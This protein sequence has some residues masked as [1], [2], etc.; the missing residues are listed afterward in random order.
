M[1]SRLKQRKAVPSVPVH[2]PKAFAGMRR[3]GTICAAVLDGIEAHVAAGITTA[4]LD[5]LCHELMRSMDATP[6]PLNYRGYPK[7]TCI[8][9]NEV[10]CHGIPDSRKLVSGDILNI[11]VT[12]I[13][14]GWHGDSSRMYFVGTPSPQA[15]RLCRVTF[16]AMW[17]GIRAARP[18]GHL[19]DIGHAIQS[20]TESQGMSVVRNYCGHGIGQEFHTPPQVLHVGLPGKGLK[21]EAGM[22]LTVEPMINLGSGETTLLEDGWTVITTD[23]SLSAQF[24]HTIAITEDG[25]EAFTLSPD[26]RHHPPW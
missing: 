26:G 4:E 21:L 24:E 18:G 11:D 12:V 5:D 1:L 25:V 9:L 19:G 14:D 6:A 20:Y 23:G 22:F 3:A 15:R 17:R 10:V 16:E 7:A 8:S 2:G 13:H